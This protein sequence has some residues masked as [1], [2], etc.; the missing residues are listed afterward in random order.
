MPW[1]KLALGAAAAKSG[2]SLQSEGTLVILVTF[3][4]KLN[5]VFVQISS[6]MREYAKDMTNDIVIVE[7]FSYFAKVG[8]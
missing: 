4:I 1:T 6:N 5:K 3:L 8:Q 2:G 7:L